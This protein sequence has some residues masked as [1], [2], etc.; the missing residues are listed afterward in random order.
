MRTSSFDL[1]WNRI[2]LFPDLGESVYEHLH[3]S[4]CDIMES[5]E[6]NTTWPHVCWCQCGEMILLQACRETP[7]KGIYFYKCPYDKV[8]PHSFLWCGVFHKD[9]PPSSMPRFLKT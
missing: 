5:D 8:H 9:D 7:N 4:F 3:S 1:P 6:N 2:E